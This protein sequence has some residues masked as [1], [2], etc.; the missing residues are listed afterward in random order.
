MGK[1]R[2]LKTLGKRIGNTVMH[3][4][5]IKHTNRPESVGHLESEEQAYRD[6]AIKEAKR[7]HWNMEDINLIKLEAI[8]FI[9]DRKDK[10]YSDVVFSFE[11]AKKLIE[12]EI[13]DLEL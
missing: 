2:I 8:D 6:S 11:E 12:E 5:L 9:K 1:N 7:Y 10:K 4:L 3:K 13:V